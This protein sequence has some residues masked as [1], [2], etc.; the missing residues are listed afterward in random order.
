[1]AFAGGAKVLDPIGPHYEVFRLEKSEN[2][3]NVLVIYTRLDEQFR[4]Q[5]DPENSVMPVFGFY[6]LMDRTNFKP[7]H[8]LIRG[9][10]AERLHVD[11]PA[12]FSETRSA[13]TVLVKSTFDTEGL[14]KQSSALTL[15]K[16][17]A[18]S[19]TTLLPTFPR[20]IMLKL[21]GQNEKTGLPEVKIF[22]QKNN[23]KKIF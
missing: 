8:S 11:V 23:Q 19:E 21:Q 4:F 2:P 9:G 14:T 15:D 22:E 3:Q 18:E 20:V 1:M 7:V 6:W 13:F 16:I 12:N 10:I 17:Y 5:L